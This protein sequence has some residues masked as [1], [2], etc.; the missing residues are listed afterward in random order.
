MG[1][2]WKLYEK[3]GTLNSQRK[4]LLSPIL[5]SLMLQRTVTTMGILHHPDTLSK[6]R[7]P[8]ATCD[9]WNENKT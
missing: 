2:E 8:W 4:M 3:P 7:G 6:E 9:E 5:F 1:F